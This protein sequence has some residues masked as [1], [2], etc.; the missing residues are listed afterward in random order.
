MKI[1]NSK[2]FFV[3]IIT[4]IASSF[5]ISCG[6]DDE[7]DDSIQISSSKDLS[8][9][10]DEVSQIQCNKKGVTY[11]SENAFVATVSNSGEIKANHVG[12]THIKVNGNEMI[13]V[14]VTPR[15]INFD[16]PVLDFG[17]SIN[18]VKAL[19]KNNPIKEEKEG[20]AYDGTGDENGRIYIFKDGKLYLSAMIVQPTKSSFLENFLVERYV[21]IDVDR[22]KPSILFVNGL[23]DETIT[24][25]IEFTVEK[26]LFVVRYFPWDGSATRSIFQIEDETLAKMK[27]F[28]EEEY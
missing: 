19:E 22:S 6:G 13:K 9:Y 8:L 10:S 7:E 4:F 11:E 1:Y 12:S 5:V 27:K 2:S 16:E 24:M 3:A 17:V 28:L 20:L 21:P 23:T 26:N 15:Y 14:T 25:I 18:K